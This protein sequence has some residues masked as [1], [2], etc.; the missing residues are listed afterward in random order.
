MG[1]TAV[2]GKQVK[3]LP[4]NSFAIYIH[5]KDIL[6]SMKVISFLVN[7]TELR[8]Q[9]IRSDGSS[10]QNPEGSSCRKG[11]YSV[12]N[13]PAAKLGVDL[14]PMTLLSFITFIINL[15]NDLQSTQLIG[16]L[17]TFHSLK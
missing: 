8:L 4:L 2:W 7:Q 10:V 14:F 11:N 16:C 3:S 9:N 1:G 5:S 15:C 13:F 17:P 6:R 12:R